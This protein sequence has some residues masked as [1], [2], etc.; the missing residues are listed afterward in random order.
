MEVLNL[1]SP[2]LL[3]GTHDKTLFDS[4]NTD[5]DDWLKRRAISN[6]VSGASRTYVVAVPNDRVVGYYALSAG[7]VG[8]AEAPGSLRR[9][10]PNPIPMVLLGRLAIDQAFQ[11]RTIGTAL[12]RHAVEQVQAAS[13]IVGIRGILVHALCERAKHFYLRHGFVEAIPGSKTLVLSLATAQPDPPT[14]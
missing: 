2:C 11:G 1:D 12:L 8:T 13:R 9:N 7:S 4:G 5:L 14:I 6:Q 10:M 3:N